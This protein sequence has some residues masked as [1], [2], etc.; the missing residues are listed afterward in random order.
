MPVNYDVVLC[1][2]YP[3]DESR[4]IIPH[5]TEHDCED[6]EI[7]GKSSLCLSSRKRGAARRP[8]PGIDV[9]FG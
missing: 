4:V 1:G 8:T 9:C 6:E 2:R 3:T 5:S 7:T